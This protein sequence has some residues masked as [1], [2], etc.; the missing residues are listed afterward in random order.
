MLT[1]DFKYKLITKL[2]LKYI[3]VSYSEKSNKLQV[4][5]SAF[6]AEDFNLIIQ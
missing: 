2:M 5:A 4:T 3:F 1:L 6:I